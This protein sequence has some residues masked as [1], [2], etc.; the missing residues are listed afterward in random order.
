MKNKTKGGESNSESREMNNEGGENDS[1]RQGESEE[2]S[3]VK[4]MTWMT[5]SPI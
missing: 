1:A 3:E 4:N 5:R 2:G